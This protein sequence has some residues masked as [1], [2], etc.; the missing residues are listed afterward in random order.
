VRFTVVGGDGPVLLDGCVWR[1]VK[2]VAHAAFER[3]P[4]LV[5]YRKQISLAATEPL[6][7]DKAEGVRN[8]PRIDE[9]LVR[10]GVARLYL[11]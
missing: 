6:D 2:A 7:A 8:A 4:I 9:I 11:R 10:V 5:L 1:Y 3:L